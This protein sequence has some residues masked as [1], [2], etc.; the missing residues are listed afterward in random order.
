MLF[1]WREDKYFRVLLAMPAAPMSPSG[2]H[3]ALPHPVFA[4]AAAPALAS[5]AGVCVELISSGCVS[6]HSGSFS[7]LP[8]MPGIGATSLAVLGGCLS[9]LSSTK[10]G[11]TLSWPCR[12]RCPHRRCPKIEEERCLGDGIVTTGS[13]LSRKTLGGQLQLGDL[14]GGGVSRHWI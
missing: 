7:G 8:A 4:S 9:G 3:V 11:C 6:R 14:R 13:C 12:L 2:P 1:S 10:L 5:P